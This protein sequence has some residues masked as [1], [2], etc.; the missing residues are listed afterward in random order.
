MD[1]KRFSLAQLWALFL[2]IFGAVPQKVQAA[3]IDNFERSV[4]A[5]TQEIDKRQKYN[6]AIRAELQNLYDERAEVATRSELATR[7]LATCAEIEARNAELAAQLNAIGAVLVTEFRDR[8]APGEDV[9]DAAI[10]VLRDLFRERADFEAL[11]GQIAGFERDEK[12]RLI[13][14]FECGKPLNETDAR[15]R[16]YRHDF[17]CAQC[18]GFDIDDSADNPSNRN[19]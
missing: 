12:G 13:F 4:R 18:G 6:V 15:T 19:E 9:H 16:A 10:R 14:C 5:L 17:V 2:R 1:D 11:A 7:T 8:C 3:A